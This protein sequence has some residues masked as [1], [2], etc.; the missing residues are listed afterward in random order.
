MADM[1]QGSPEWLDARCGK[2]TA[3]RVADVLAV[4][5]DGKPTAERERYLMELVGERLTGL[6]TSHYLTGP[7]LEGSE[8]EPQ[9]ADAYAFLYGADIEKVGFVEHPSIAMAG[10][11]PDRL[12]GDLGLVEIKCPTLRTHLDTLLTG[13]IPDQYLP[14]MRWQ[15]ACTGRAWCDF[16]TWHPGVPPHL[17][18]WVKRLHRDDA[19]IAKDEAAVSTFLSEVDARVAKLLGTDQAEAA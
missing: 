16:A 12:V 14:Q 7:M 13:E 10:A 2:V 18:L 3:S 4:K 6:A 19:Q 9:A 15:M 17:R 11:S 8:R 1:V 5:R